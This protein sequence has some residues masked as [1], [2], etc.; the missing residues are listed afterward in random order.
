MNF[1]TRLPKVQGEDCIYV[2]VD[3]LTMYGHFIAISTKQ[4]APQVIE[5]FFKKFFKLHDLPRDTRITYSLAYF[6]KNS[7]T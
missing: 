1:I 2:I 3:P 4:Q 7:S 6:E 5:V